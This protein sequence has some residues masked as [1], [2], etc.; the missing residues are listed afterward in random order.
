M[1]WISEINC[2]FLS[3]GT[4]LLRRPAPQRRAS[5]SRM[6][7]MLN[8]KTNCNICDRRDDNLPSPVARWQLSVKQRAVKTN[9]R[10]RRNI[11][12]PRRSHTIRARFIKK[13]KKKRRKGGQK[14]KQNKT[15]NPN[16]PL[17]SEGRDTFRRLVLFDGVGQQVNKNKE[18]TSR[19]MD[20]WM[21]RRDESNVFTQTLANDAN[22]SRRRLSER[23]G[24]Y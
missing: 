9:P 18:Q 23:G 7:E 12:E 21:G 5:C 3:F 4:S 24:V 22:A 11:T 15:Q 16:N 6:V 10:V 14:K 13:K 20:G 17:R 1:R 19:K 8:N 2:I